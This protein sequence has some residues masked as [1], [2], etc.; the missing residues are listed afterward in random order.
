MSSYRPQKRS[1][2][3]ASLSISRQQE[4]EYDKFTSKRAKLRA[5]DDSHSHS[6]KRKHSLS[7][8][9]AKNNMKD[10]NYIQR[11][12]GQTIVIETDRI[13]L[14]QLR[15][16]E[17]VSRIINNQKL[18]SPER[19]SLN[20]NRKKTW[21]AKKRSK[22]RSYEIS[23][24]SRTTSKH[25]KS[26]EGAKKGEPRHERKQSQKDQSI[27]LVPQSAENNSMIPVLAT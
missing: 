24:S 11:K 15:K 12:R 20:S 3:R 13:S 5:H 14:N 7:A 9:K 16:I 6:Q 8:R 26:K 10:L 18:K 4:K 2:Q 21:S 25:V 17:K 1:K 19:K 22:K 27:V 23:P